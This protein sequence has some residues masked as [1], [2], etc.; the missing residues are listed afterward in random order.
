MCITLTL[1]EMVVVWHC[2]V[3]WLISSFRL[4]HVWWWRSICSF[5]S[6]IV[7][8]ASDWLFSF[9]F[10]ALTSFWMIFGWFKYKRFNRFKNTLLHSIL[11]F[12]LSRPLPQT[13]KYRWVF[14]LTNVVKKQKHST[15]MGS[16]II[17][18][19]LS[20]THLPWQLWKIGSKC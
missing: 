11:H 2:N 7:S 3:F 12:W 14:Y 19:A 15:W 1:K 20:A 9:L 10:S 5:S 6:Y 17:K 13:L 16:E 4:M 8:C 18:L